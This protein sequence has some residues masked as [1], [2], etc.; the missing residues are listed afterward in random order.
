VPERKIGAE[1]VLSVTKKLEPSRFGRQRERVP[2][3]VC[4]HRSVF[5]YSERPPQLEEP[6]L[7]IYVETER[8]DELLATLSQNERFGYRHLAK[9]VLE[10]LKNL[11]LV[12]A[13]V[14][15]VVLRVGIQTG[16]KGGYSA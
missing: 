12:C 10:R 13:A 9:V 3:T 14:T 5:P 16:E 8:P 4:Y 11:G 2:K 1:D 15:D 7:Y 6:G